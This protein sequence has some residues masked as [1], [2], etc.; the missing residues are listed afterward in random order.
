MEVKEKEENKNKRKKKKE[1]GKD[2]KREGV[3][4]QL[5]SNTRLSITFTILTS[6]L[7]NTNRGKTVHGTLLKKPVIPIRKE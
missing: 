7:N 2:H 5:V 4:I 3:K 6:P 1:G